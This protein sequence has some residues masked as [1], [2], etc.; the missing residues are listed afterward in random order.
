MPVS[1][2]LPSVSSV[3][4]ASPGSPGDG[5]LSGRAG[6]RRRAGLVSGVRRPIAV[7]M[8]LLMTA[9]GVSVAPAVWAAPAASDGP[10]VR[11]HIQKHTFANASAPFVDDS[12]FYFWRHTFTAEIDEPW[13][14]GKVTYAW[15]WFRGR[16]KIA[17]AT[18]H[19][20][21][22][23]L[24]DIGEHV[25]VRLT[26]SKKGYVTKSLTSNSSKL[27]LPRPYTTSHHPTISGAFVQGSTLTAHH[28]LYVPTP[29][30]WKYQW[31]R[32][33][34]PISHATHVTYVQTSMDVGHLVT[35]RADPQRV[36]Y[37]PAAWDSENTDFTVGPIG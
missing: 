14:S 32:D 25:R 31:M 34:V 13:A 23:Q 19:T 22:T 17:H 6:R 8:V 11:V 35:V 30:S 20:Y 21:R 7:A 2:S 3:S 27:I 29:T 12:T 1:V 16:H 9:A 26:A 5:G 28:G 18:H 10:A 15:Q 36:G 4:A 37:Q 33:G 24:A